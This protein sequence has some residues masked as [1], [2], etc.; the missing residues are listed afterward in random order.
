ME[1]GCGMTAILVGFATFVVQL[2]RVVQGMRP[3]RTLIDEAIYD[4]VP[5]ILG[6]A[7][8]TNVDSRARS[9]Y[10]FA[11]SLA[12]MAYFARK[13]LATQQDKAPRPDA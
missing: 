11:A 7:L 4:L 12:L 13:L 3:A 10:F 1:F 6:V 8:V 9:Y 2:V 5:L